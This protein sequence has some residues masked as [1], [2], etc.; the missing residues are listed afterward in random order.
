MSEIIT[1]S[2]CDSYIEQLAGYI[3]EHYI[4]PG[5]DLSRLAVCFGGK[6]P[7]LFIQRELARRIGKVYY[8]PAFF[9][10]DDFMAHVMRQTTA[11]E[12]I[13]DLDNCYRLYQLACQ[14]TPAILRGRE[15]FARFL[16]WTREIIRF[17]DN[18]DLEDIPNDDLKNIEANAQI[19][20]AVPAD[21]NDLLKALVKLREAYHRHLAGQAQYTRGMQY[22]WVARHIQDIPLP[23]FDQILFCNFFYFNRTEERVIKHLHGRG[24][25]TLIF[26]G[27]ERKWPV[28]TRMAK[29]FGCPL[30]E[31]DEPPVPGF[32]LKL[33]AGFDT[34]SQMGLARRVLESIPQAERDKT[35]I[36]LPNPE[37]VVSLMSEIAPLLTDYNISMG[38]PL[39]RSSLYSLMEFVL[40]AQLSRK[41][42]LYYAKDYL[43]ALKHP[44]VKNLRLNTK[45]V[46]TRIL[47][48]KIEEVLTGKVVDTVSGS[49]FVDLSDVEKSETVYRLTS[50]MLDRLNE[51]VPAGDLRALCAQVHQQ[52]FRQWEAVGNFQAF[53]HV[54]AGFLLLLTEKSF[55]TQWPLNEQIAERLFMINEEFGRAAFSGEP[56]SLQE[57]FKVFESKVSR[58]MVQLPG[59]PLKGL[60]ILGLMETRSLN[61]RHV[62]VLDVNEGSLPHLDIYEPLIPREVMISLNLDRLEM[63]EE[64]QRYQFMRLISSAQNVHLIY[65]KSR[66]KERSRFVEELI[67]EKEKQTGR[68]GA[69]PVTRGSY[70]VDVGRPLKRVAKTPAMLAVLRQHKYS[71]SSINTYLRDPMEFYYTYVLGLRE[72]EDLLDEPEARRVGTFMHGLLEESFQRF[73]GQR[74]VIDADFRRDVMALFEKRFAREFG[75]GMKSDAFL[76]KAVMEERLGRFLDTEAERP[77]RAI[78]ELMHLEKRFNDEIPLSCGAIRFSYIVDRIDRLADGTIMILDYKTGSTGQMPQALKKVK[79]MELSRETILETVKSFQIPLYFYYLHK[80]YPGQ[81]I[82]AAV[83]SLRTMKL[84]KF[85]QDGRHPDYDE[86]NAAFMRPLDFVMSEILN[87]EVDFVEAPQEE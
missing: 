14:V 35:V 3:D 54:F 36:V 20:Y 70:R 46:A 74:P 23:E 82:N 49:L 34:H 55:L 78:D 32:D 66:E 72:A 11:F 6:R 29:S 25:A 22:R 41:K 27:D 59:S 84:E 37:H 79:A 65:Q 19:G 69:M 77:E 57:M 67:W 81:R 53:S 48:H 87:P 63:E 42:G 24:Q 39:R 9:T 62:I 2:F 16:P 83:Y 71:A 51:T 31:A 33:H 73:V 76:L 61:F 15:T 1:Y 7:R 75:R 38:Y 44:F 28:L 12:P 43:K 10:I 26:Q 40:R 17:I 58:G 21:I 18:L 60:Q 52:V 56:F 80:Q 30:K 50:E 13:L 68:Y 86:V 45:P 64:I 47:V 5:R 8:P 4:R 85:F